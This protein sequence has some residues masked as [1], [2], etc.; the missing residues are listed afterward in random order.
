MPLTSLKDKKIL[1]TGGAG[2]IGANLVRRLI[3]EGADVHLF[4]RPSSKRNRLEDI[5]KLV[6]V[7]E[8]DLSDEE[9]VRALMLEIKPN[10]VFHLAAVN[11]FFGYVPTV[12]ELTATNIVATTKLMDAVDTVDYD[13]FVNTG[14][15][16]EV[17]AKEAPLRE[18]DVCEP[19]EFYSIS[20]IP[21]TLYGQALAK[22]KGKPIVTIRVFTPYGPFG[23]TT[24]IVHKVITHALSGAQVT[25]SRPT[26]TRDFIYIDDL[27]DLYITVA[28]HAREQKGH[29]FNG[30]SGVATSLGELSA[31]VLKCTDSQSEVEWASADGPAYDNA[32]WQA[33]TS[34]VEKLLLWKPAHTLPEG[35]QK[36]AEWFRAHQDYWTK[37]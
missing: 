17:G 31:L 30:G 35:L 12:D 9:K 13:F 32:R 19:T 18:D 27:V 15:F 4:L 16:T 3:E 36:T 6:T 25:L 34:K 26:V 8:V 28:S 23:D 33:D 14:T 20:R 21:G 10:G 1:V 7:H 2:F 11:Q 29:I 24:K 37:Q 22:T 5:I